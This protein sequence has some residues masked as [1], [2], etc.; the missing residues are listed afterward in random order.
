MLRV[1]EDQL[2]GEVLDSD[3]QCLQKS[4]VW[5]HEPATLVLC[6]SWDRRIL[7]FGERPCLKTDKV[8]SNRGRHCTASSV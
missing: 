3:P 8:K 6:G 4:G 5:W 2:P 1:M 7:R